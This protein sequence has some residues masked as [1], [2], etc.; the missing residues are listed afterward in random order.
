MISFEQLHVLFVFFWTNFVIVSFKHGVT[1]VFRK[2]VQI[3]ICH[4]CR[5]PM[6]FAGDIFCNTLRLYDGSSLIKF[7]KS[8]SEQ[9]SLLSYCKRTFRLSKHNLSWFKRAL[10]RISES[11]L[12]IMQSEVSYMEQKKMTRVSD[13]SC[14]LVKYGRLVT[15]HGRAR[16]FLR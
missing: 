6:N 11:V 3:T 14:V 5:K 8:F 4:W 7:T 2:S 10:N 16:Y 12:L 9:Y 13:S 1:K 15:G